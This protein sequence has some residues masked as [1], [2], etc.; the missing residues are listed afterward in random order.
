[1]K[2]NLMRIILLFCF[3]LNFLSAQNLNQK[4]LCQKAVDNLAE[5]KDLAGSSISI[6]LMNAQT[7]QIIAEWD[8]ERRLIPA[9]TL[10]LITCA[11][12]LITCSD[13]LELITPFQ[14]IGKQIQDSIFEGDIVIIGK[15]DPSFGS[16]NMK[17]AMSVSQIA[18]T[19]MV[20]LNRL[21][22]REIRGRV[23]VNS[24][25]IKDV[26]ENPEWL[27]YDIANYY[28]AGVYGFNVLENSAYLNLEKV[29][30]TNSYEISSV[31]PV[32]VKENFTNK[33]N[34]SNTSDDEEDLYFLGSS[35]CNYISLNGKIATE[36]NVATSVKSCL[37]DPA[38][39]Y[40]LMLQNQLITRG[41]RMN[42]VYNGAIIK[43]TIL[44]YNHHSPN[45]KLLVQYT[46]KNSV[47]LYCESFVHQI[48]NTWNKNTDRSKS[49]RFI[50]DFWNSKI[51]QPKGVKMIDGSGLSR[52]NKISS[53]VLSKI[54]FN[55][56]QTKKPEKYYE[57]I[58]DVTSHPGLGLN[59]IK[60]KKLRGVYRLK[61][62]S[63][64]GVRAYSGYLLYNGKPK[65]ILSI[66][67][68]N[69]DCPSK[70]ISSHVAKLLKEWDG[71]LKS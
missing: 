9:S 39:T 55:I 22:I 14:L 10:K 43:D 17:E 58:P 45:I 28:G 46:L 36:A 1:M 64:D 53:E 21:N 54:L 42:Y 31:Y 48:G 44:I 23:I 3:L 13:T 52:K 41:L 49:L 32:E 51:K 66:L 6:T 27:Y 71:I 7:G 20:L 62:G 34:Y 4:A 38:T 19:L 16:G 50:S 61:S 25:F 11:S 68:N 26:P 29:D 2:C 47:N 33:I 5:Q 56:L 60:G 70:V 12:T 30:S 65:Y 35:S 67:I 40:S 15:G 69:Y 57:L 37:P 8:K 24:D 18:D 59:K 63:M